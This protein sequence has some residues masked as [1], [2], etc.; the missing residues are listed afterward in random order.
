MD[1]PGNE[2]TESPIHNPVNQ[3]GVA[4]IVPTVVMAKVPGIDSSLIRTSVAVVVFG[5]AL[6][7]GA[8]DS[9]GK[10]VL[11]AT[12]AYAAVLIV[13]VGTSIGG[14][15]RGTSADSAVP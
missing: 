3:P 11:A 5:T 7:F 14:G 12:A 8:T 15:T 10:D 2:I 9:T 4:L 6:A 1:S 13:F